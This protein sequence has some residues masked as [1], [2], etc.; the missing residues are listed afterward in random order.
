MTSKKTE[1]YKI[2]GMNLM[3]ARYDYGKLV[4]SYETM[5][6]TQF[7]L[8]MVPSGVTDILVDGKQVFSTMIPGI[9]GLEQLLSRIRINP[10]AASHAINER[11]FA[12]YMMKSE[13]ELR[14]GQY[15]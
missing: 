13:E 12:E 10:L 5:L 3:T 14:R 15:F 11:T 4:L 9:D 8:V 1:N 7:E 2:E 6:A